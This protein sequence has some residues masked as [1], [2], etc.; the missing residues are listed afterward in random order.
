MEWFEKTLQSLSLFNE[1]YDSNMLLVFRI[2]AVDIVRW[3]IGV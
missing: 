1:H 3:R 2:K